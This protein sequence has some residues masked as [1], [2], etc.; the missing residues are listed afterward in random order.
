MAEP[1]F[2]KRRQRVYL[3]LSGVFLG[4]LALLNVLGISRF[5]DL[6]FELFGINV[7]M[8]VAIGVLPYPITF[9]CTDLISELFGEKKARDMVWV[10]LLLNGWVVFLLWL[11][12]ALPGFEPM[13]PATG[14]P[15]T[16]AAGRLPVF[17]EV[18]QLA[19]GAV[20][21]SMIAYLAA[22]FCDV[23]LFHFWKKLT[24]GRHLWLRNN[25]ST[26]TSQMVDTTAVILITHFYAHALPIDEAAPLAPQL[27][28]FILS[29]YVFKLL[30]AAVDTGPV[31]LLV[32]WLRPYLGLKGTE[33]ATA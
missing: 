5:L 31:Y 32:R 25:A 14:L 12:G 29:G 4:T 26:M 11:G 28:T 9:L 3:V 1:N 10:G 20:A 6:S 23:R 7:P 15:Q 30:V 24:G 22:Q 17:F 16:D 27:L 33:E 13:D 2:E 8:V 18:R 21:A 19:F